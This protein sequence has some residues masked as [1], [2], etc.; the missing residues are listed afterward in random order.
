MVDRLSA[1][2]IG[3]HV[4][5]HC[6]KMRCPKSEMVGLVLSLKKKWPRC[7]VLVP[8]GLLVKVC[9]S[10]FVFNEFSLN[11]EVIQAQV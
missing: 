2:V 7:V 3:Q 9:L 10:V 1:M 8:L 6:W 11:C 4:E 5:P